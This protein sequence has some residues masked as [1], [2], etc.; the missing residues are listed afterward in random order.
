MRYPSAEV[1]GS[2]LSPIQPEL[3]ALFT[4]NV[5][6]ANKPAFP[7]TVPSRLRMWKTNG[8][9]SQKFD[10]IHGRLLVSCFRNHRG[11]LEQAFKHLAPGGWLEMQDADF[12]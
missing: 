1:I 12:P 9:Y 3:Y 6:T 4:I 5:M 2:D 10:L 8:T 11:V 7:Q